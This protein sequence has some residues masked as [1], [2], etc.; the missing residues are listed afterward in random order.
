MP[1]TVLAEW[2]R[3]TDVTPSL[4]VPR[5]GLGNLSSHEPALSIHLH[6]PV[7]G[8]G[9]LRE[10]E[11]LHRY[12]LKKSYLTPGLESL[13]AREGELRVHKGKLTALMSMG[14]V[15]KPAADRAGEEQAFRVTPAWLK[16][17]LRH[18]HGLGEQ[19]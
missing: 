16:A 4:R 2:S 17:Q 13:A 1:T 6:Q 5:R 3:F 18:Q 12:R 15:Y 9:W 7:A 8:N 14:V 19:E 11:Q 10:L